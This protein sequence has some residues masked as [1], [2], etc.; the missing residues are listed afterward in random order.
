VLKNPAMKNENSVLLLN[1]GIHYPISLHFKHFQRLISETAKI[2]MPKTTL[3]MSDCQMIQ[4]WTRTPY[5]IWKTTTAME[6]E[7]IPAKYLN[8]SSIRFQTN[9]VYIIVAR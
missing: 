3:D 6:R 7:K 4:P 1:L 5:V 2:L 9:Q 8:A